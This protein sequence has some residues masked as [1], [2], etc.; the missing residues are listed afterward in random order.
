MA[1]DGNN[2]YP[3]KPKVPSRQ[4][5]GKQ[6]SE[7]KGESL[8]RRA[9]RALSA[10]RK[11]MD[12]LQRERE[13]FLQYYMAQEIGNEVEGH[14]KV[15]MS[16]V[17]DTI[18]S[19]MP[20]MMRI[21]YG[22]KGVLQVGPVGPE[23][24]IKAKLMEEKVN[25]DIQKQNDGFR[26]IHTFVKDS[27]LH[28]LGVIK[29]SWKRKTVWRKRRYKGLTDGELA[30]LTA[31]PDMQIDSMITYV[32][33]SKGKK[34]K[35]SKKPML[36][37]VWGKEV[38]YD[39]SVREVRERISKPN[40][41][42]LPPEEFIFNLMGRS[43]ETMFCAH[44]KKVHRNALKKYG[45]SSEDV[46]N[47]IERVESEGLVLERFKDLGGATFV[48]DDKE[49]PFVFIYECYMNDYDKDGETI[50]KK[51]VIFADRVLTE[52]EN[53]YGKPPFVVASP[54]LMPHRLCGRSYAELLIE[55]QQLRTALVRYIL[56]NIY[57]QNNAM[58]VVNPYRVDLDSLL[59]GNRPGGVALTKYDIDPDKALF[60]IPIEPIPPHVLKMLEYVE[61]P[62]RENRTG[63]TRYSQGMDASSLNDTATGVT[64]IMSASAK[65]TE[66]L[67]R[68]LAETG[69]KDLYN[70]C[71]QLN[72]DYFD[73]DVN[74][75]INDE[76]QMIR[77][78]DIDGRFDVT[79]EVG[80]ST[81]TKDMQYQQKVQMLNIYGMIAGVLG[82]QTVEIFNAGNIKNMI[83]N[84]WEDL[85]V[86]NTDLYVAPDQTGGAGGQLPAEAA[87]GLIAGGAPGGVPAPGGGGGGAI[88]PSALGAV[89]QGVGGQV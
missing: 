35:V 70:A 23:D 52:E 53:S 61:G 54:I 74:L 12:T 67:A 60:N 32:A 82:P 66:L 86:R 29:Y 59:N 87:G 22:G 25:F 79:V 72:I 50:P 56:D 6:V 16:D 34:K 80:S 5:V 39:V 37:D 18:E 9:L 8:K 24:E 41:E 69:M 65:R 63:V 78:E 75:K 15:V 30:A 48:T 7:E 88:D 55:I 49:G 33:D 1:Y 40:F 4:Q 2:A 84:M 26:L 14:S 43:I 68:V 51:V 71:V 58:R 83:R 38:T 46:K 13:K 31:R 44:K 21:F 89:L 10:C 28:K 81:G 77:P 3:D 76:W 57:Y 11:D 64:Q 62:I 42:N 20:D 47:E 45:L 36:A 17:S 19:L 27:L 85:G 73:A